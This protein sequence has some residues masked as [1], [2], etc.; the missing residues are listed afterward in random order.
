MGC[1]RDLELAEFVVGYAVEI[2][3]QERHGLIAAYIPGVGAVDD[4]GHAHRRHRRPAECRI[5]AL[6]ARVVFARPT[7]VKVDAASVVDDLE[8]RPTAV[9]RVL[10]AYSR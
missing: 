4:C 3:T 5:V 1:D 6:L 9:Y 7:G 10:L 2:G 8:R